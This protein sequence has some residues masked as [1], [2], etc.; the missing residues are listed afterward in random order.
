VQNGR[1]GLLVS[2]TSRT[3]CRGGREASFGA[4]SRRPTWEEKGGSACWQIF[5]SPATFSRRW[6][7]TSGPSTASHTTVGSWQC[8]FRSEAVLVTAGWVLALTLCESLVA[9]GY[10]VVCVDNFFTGSRRNIAHRLAFQILSSFATTYFPAVREVDEIYNLACPRI[11]DTLPARS[12]PDDED[13]RSGRSIC[14]A[15]RSECEPES[16]RPRRRSL[17]RPSDARRRSRSNW[18]TSI[19]S[20]CDRATTRVNAAPRRCFSTITSATACDQSC[21][22][23]QH[24]TGRH[25]PERWAGR[26]ELIVQALQASR[27]RSMATG[28]RRARSATSTT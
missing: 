1:T 13:E 18:V 28:S 5:R 15:L 9:E 21:S 25:A 23:F 11:P 22:H 26:F 17:R 8:T 19:Q 10:D 3:A 24:P 7:Y 2:R 12:S 6:R 27:S 20:A 4:Q 16:S 14:S